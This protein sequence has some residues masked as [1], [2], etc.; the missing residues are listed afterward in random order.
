MSGLTHYMVK[1][2]IH[3]FDFVL[4][5]GLSSADLLSED[6]YVQVGFF[7]LIC[8]DLVFKLA[9]SWLKS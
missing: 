3:G 9:D 2:T 5:S 4:V 6:L 7:T 8:D 1:W